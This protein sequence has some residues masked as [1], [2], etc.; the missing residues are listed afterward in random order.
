MQ[1]NILAS[2][3]RIVKRYFIKIFLFLNF[4]QKYGD[5]PLQI[6]FF[7]FLKTK[8]KKGIDFLEILW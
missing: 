3:F 2:N 7:H 8:I 5:F 6:A 1:F 4:F